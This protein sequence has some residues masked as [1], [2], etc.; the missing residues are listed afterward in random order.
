MALSFETSRLKVFEISGDM[1][2]SE[3][4]VL[5]NRVP[6]ILTPPVVE[7]LPPYFHG[8]NSKADAQAW[9][10]RMISE[11]RLFLVKPADEDTVI[12]FVFAFVEN[13]CD[14][15]IGY[16]LGEQYWGKGLASELLQGVIEQSGKTESWVK[17]IG[18][19]DRSNQASAKLLQ[20][21]GFVEQSGGD[22]DV[23]FYEYSFSQPQS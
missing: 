19:V 4:T 18:G 5:L 7:N 2:P 1:A 21:L 13:G 14:A 6:D 12:G 16:L 22:S 23:V 10:E 20:K 11:S 9:F 8:I 15:H 3:L 17:L